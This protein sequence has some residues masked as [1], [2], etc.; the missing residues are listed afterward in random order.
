[1]ILESSQPCENCLLIHHAV[2]PVVHSLEI[3]K[4]I[5]PISN[6]VHLYNL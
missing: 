1:M 3:Y 6:L 2:F 5:L 4:H